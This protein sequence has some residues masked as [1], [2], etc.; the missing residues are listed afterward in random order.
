MIISAIWYHYIGDS[1]PI[2]Y[3]PRRG[4]LAPLAAPLPSVFFMELR[5]RQ[6]LSACRYKDALQLVPV[7][8]YYHL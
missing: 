7:S 1:V 3:M 6:L 5:L 4:L 2:T 8:R